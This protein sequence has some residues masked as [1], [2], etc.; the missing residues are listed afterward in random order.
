MGCHIAMRLSMI[1]NLVAGC[2]EICMGIPLVCRRRSSPALRYG[3]R[4]KSASVPHIRDKGASYLCGTTLIPVARHSN[5]L[6][7]ARPAQ[8]TDLCGMFGALLRGDTKHTMSAALHHPAVLWR[9]RED[10]R[11]LIVALDSIVIH[12]RLAGS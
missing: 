5:A 7:R 4:S 9:Q 1:W 8:S 3:S 11:V 2:V 12:Q 10:L 6:Y